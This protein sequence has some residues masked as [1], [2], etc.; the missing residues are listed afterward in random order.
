MKT[1]VPQT[2][3]SK[4]EKRR[5]AA[6]KR[7]TWAFSPV[8]RTKE[9]KKRFRREKVSPAVLQDDRGDLFFSL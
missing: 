4:R 8:T 6:E 1:P 3:L 9:S 2:K 5:R 7:V